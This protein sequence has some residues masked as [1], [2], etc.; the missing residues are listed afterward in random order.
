MQNNTKLNFCSIKNYSNKTN[1]G[2]DWIALSGEISKWT[3][4]IN[5]LAKDII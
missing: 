3:N 4:K 2:G 1:L 5:T